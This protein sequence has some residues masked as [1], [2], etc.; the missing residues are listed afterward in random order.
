MGERSGQRGLFVFLKENGFIAIAVG[1][2][3]KKAGFMVTRGFGVAV[4]GGDACV[5]AGFEA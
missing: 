5:H 4:A 1:N 3:V 2:W